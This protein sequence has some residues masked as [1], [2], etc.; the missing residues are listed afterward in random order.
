LRLL[1][2]TAGATPCVAGGRH[3]YERRQPE[4]GALYQ[5]VRENLQ[6][7]YAAVEQG[8]AAP[9]PSSCAV[10]SS[11]ICPAACFAEASP[12]SCAT[13]EGAWPRAEPT[14]WITCWPRVPLRQFVVT[15][16]FELRARLA[17]DGA[18]LG[19]VGR[20][21]VDSVLASTGEGCGMKPARSAGVA[22]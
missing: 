20:I 14:W 6:T 5:V 11:S 22:R 2:T 21:V 15:L 9:C 12:S 7:L 8:C 17:Y 19:A 3:A 18:L 4:R 1:L 16:P 13:W 10:S